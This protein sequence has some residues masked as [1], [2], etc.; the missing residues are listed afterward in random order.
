[1]PVFATVYNDDL[2]V[3]TRHSLATAAAIKSLTVHL[4][5]E[6][7]HDGLTASGTAVLDHLFRM[8]RNPRPL[9]QETTPCPQRRLVPTAETA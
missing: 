5:D 6:H 3:Y 4:T 9:P 7:E 1:M 2:Y 8:A